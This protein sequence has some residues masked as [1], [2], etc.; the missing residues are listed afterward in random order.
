MKSFKH[1]TLDFEVNKPSQYSEYWATLFLYSKKQNNLESNINLYKK[2]LPL[3]TDSKFY[4][5]EDRFTINTTTTKHDASNKSYLFN[6]NQLLLLNTTYK[7]QRTSLFNTLPTWYNLININ[8]LRKEML[9][10]K[11]KYSRSPAYDTV[12]GGAAA[13]F[14][15]FLGFLVS[16][17]FGMELVDSGDFYFLI[18]YIVFLCFSL[19]PLLLTINPSTPL[20]EIFSIRSILNFYTNL[21]TLFFSRFK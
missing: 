12:S 16:E 18:M 8:F 15:G 6:L 7:K 13:L 1:I 21:I 9:Y 19:R 10:T 20:Q 11:L 2:F 5:K 17:K 14:A 3:N 4:L